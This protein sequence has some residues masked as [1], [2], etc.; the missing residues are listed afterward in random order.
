MD[1]LLLLVVCGGGLRE[2]LGIEGFPICL[3]FRARR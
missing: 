1:A 2:Y 3:L